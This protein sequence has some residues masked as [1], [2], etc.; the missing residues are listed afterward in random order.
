MEYTYSI[1]GGSAALN[2]SKDVNGNYTSNDSIFI[3]NNNN[4]YYK[5]DLVGLKLVNF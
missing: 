3:S 1:S 4:A 5:T 2:V